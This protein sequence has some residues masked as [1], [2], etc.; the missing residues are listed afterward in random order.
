MSFLKEFVWEFIQNLVLLT[1]FFIALHFWQRGNV[2]IGVLCAVGGG[3]LGAWNIRWIEHAHKGHAEPIRVTLTNS[4][5]MPL[6]MVVFVAYLAAG[7]SS[8]QSDLALGL[9]AGVALSVAQRV[10]IQAPLDV[11]RSLAFALAFPI[12][13]LCIRWLAANAPV[14]VSILV[15]T[16]VVTLPIVAIHQGSKRIKTSGDQ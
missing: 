16:T 15:S 4:V 11:A 7:W 6:L 10:A 5:V 13:L 1:G 3:I 14:S 2:I 12:T 8:W 9:V